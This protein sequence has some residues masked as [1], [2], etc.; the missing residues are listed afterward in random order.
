M[1]FQIPSILQ[2]MVLNVKLLKV[3]VL[4]HDIRLV[5]FIQA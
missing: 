5:K 4:D 3:G 1:E 2:L